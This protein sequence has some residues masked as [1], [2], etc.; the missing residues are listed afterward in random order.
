M[1]V[2]LADGTVVS[3]TDPRAQALLGNQ[4]DVIVVQQPPPPPP[5]AQPET[6]S[7]AEMIER[8]EAARKE[9]KDK[10]YG[11][12]D[13]LNNRVK[14]FEDERQR[15][16]DEAAAAQA[17]ADEAARLAAQE[18]QTISERYQQLEQ[19]WQERFNEQDQRIQTQQQLFEKEREF[20]QLA[21]YRN[22]RLAELK[23]QIDPRFHDF[24]AGN[25]PDE[26]EAA[27]YVA[28]EKTAAIGQEFQSWAEQQGLV[29]GGQ[30]QPSRLPGVPVT[31]GPA[32][33][34]EQMSGGVQEVTL[35]PEDIANMPMS[36]FAANREQLLAA[37]S[38]QVSEGGLYGERR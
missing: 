15:L 10:L 2:T 1:T 21:N 8:V 5:Q 35:T 25:S 6:V 34:P 36:E 19:T 9:E 14:V 20:Q 38:R 31:S 37:A 12:L 28:A 7:V 26:I 27:L 17:A 32:F 11:T 24:V 13:T 30:R 23:E 16:A 29:Q 22:T 4:R 18:E 3:A 33:T